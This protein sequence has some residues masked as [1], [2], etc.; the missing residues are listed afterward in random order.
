MENRRI[1]GGLL[2]AVGIIVP[3]IG[4]MMGLTISAPLGW[5]LLSLCVVAALAGLVMLFWPS[6]RSSQKRS[7]PR[8]SAVSET[9]TTLDLE[10][11]D[12]FRVRKMD[13][14]AD[15]VARVRHSRDVSAGEIVHRP[16][17][18][19]SERQG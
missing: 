7:E 15:T 3:W 9:A 14:S 6:A 11:V 2:A 5:L 17:E 1:G 12:G 16:V 18:K 13:S 8:N 19:N 10:G 4:Q